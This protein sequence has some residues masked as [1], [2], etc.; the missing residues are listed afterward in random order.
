MPEAGVIFIAAGAAYAQA[1]TQAARS[2]RAQSPSLSV[3]L[4]TDAPE[5]AAH[6]IFNRVHAIESPHARSKVDHMH[7]SRFERTLYL[8][9]DIRV[10]ADITEMFALLDRFDIAAAHAHSRNREATNAIW[11][12]EIPPSFPQ[13]NGGVILYRKSPTVLE[14]LRAWQ[15]AYHQA[16]FKKDQVTLRELLWQSDLRLHILPPEYNIRYEKYLSVWDE[17]EA[18]PKILHFAKFHSPLK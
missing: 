8:D 14:F 17:K 3:D 6:E 9:A 11:R 15:K 1:A 2:V 13:V 16:G 10:V 4:F 12:V 7:E 5:A 18:V